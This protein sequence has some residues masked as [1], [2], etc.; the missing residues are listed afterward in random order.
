MFRLADK[1]MYWGM[2]RAYQNPT[3]E[4]AMALHKMIRLVTCTLSGEG[5]LNFMGNEF[6]HP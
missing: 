3:V 5:Y 1:E 6:G 4:R 2:N